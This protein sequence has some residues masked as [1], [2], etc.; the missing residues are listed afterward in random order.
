MASL[1]FRIIL[2]LCIRADLA[3]RVPESR[4]T[5]ESQRTP[6]RRKLQTLGDLRPVFL[7]ALAHAA[8]SPPATA[9]DLTHRSHDSSS[10]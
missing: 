1:L 9:S 6:I 3:V 2:S 8:P 7:T 5:L 4:P 10:A